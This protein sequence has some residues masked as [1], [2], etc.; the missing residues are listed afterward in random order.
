MSKNYSGKLNIAFIHPD[1]GI[2]GAERLVVDAA[3]GLQDQGH[4]VTIYTSHC[5]KS[6][7][8]EEIANE[9]LKVEVIG[10]S[11]PTNFK[12]KFFILFANIRQLYLI[13]KLMSTGKIWDFD[14]FIIDQLS[15]CIPLLHYIT[16]TAKILFYC[17][18]PDQLLCQR[19]TL[20]KKLYRIPFDLFE[21]FSISASDSILVNSKFTRIIYHQTFKYLNNDP[22]V[23]YPCVD[24]SNQKIESQDKDLLNLILSKNDKF[25]LSI[26][27]YE[28]KKNIELALK[29][30]SLSYASKT[31]D[32]KLIIS[33]GY[34]SRVQENVEYLKE[35]ETLSN[36]LNLSISTIFYPNYCVNGKECIDSNIKNSQVIFLISISSSLKELLLQETK[37]LL[38]TPSF[39][40]FGIVPLE[41]MKHGKPVL[42]VNNGGPVETVIDLVPGKNELVATGWLR[43]ADPVVWALVIDEFKEYI[44]KNI[45]FAKNGPA[46]VKSHFSRSA[47]TENFNNNIERIIWKERRLHNW[48]NFVTFLLNLI[49]HIAIHNIFG[50][51]SW[52]Y[53]FIAI[54]YI[55]YF[56]NYTWGFYWILV[57]IFLSYINE[58]LSQ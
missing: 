13:L 57:F 26:N 11:L 3:V 12:G 21:S 17:H 27:R 48:E 43:K 4:N 51:K 30:F 41:A 15:T 7:C 22:A 46:H 2:G 53:L 5:D 14:L 50:E 49:L 24:L 25:F 18:F 34:D 31:K 47:M 39:E 23:V 8:F 28:R 9:S 58:I 35:L 29:A 52:P 36:E 6:H 45:I 42:A 38:Y 55:S 44:G 56:K 1:L 54:L 10:D 20:I 32:V 16:N 33:G 19:S 40:H 37:I